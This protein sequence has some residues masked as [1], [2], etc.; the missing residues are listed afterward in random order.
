MAQD[1]VKPPSGK[2]HRKHVPFSRLGADLLSATSGCCAV[3]VVVAIFVVVAAA[4]ARLWGFG[5]AII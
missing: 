3:A 1:P 2:K 4:V 5:L